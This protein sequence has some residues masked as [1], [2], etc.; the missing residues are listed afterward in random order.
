MSVSI[1]KRRKSK[2]VK[3]PEDVLRKRDPL[4]EAHAVGERELRAL[5]EPV[6]SVF[7]GA[8]R[9]EIEEIERND[10]EGMLAWGVRSGY[11]WWVRTH[12]GETPT[13]AHLAIWHAIAIAERMT[14]DCTD[15]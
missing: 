6:F 4:S 14:R 10:R 13:L 11:F 12:P 1:L 7:T 8:Q 5:W 15:D 9:D 3:I 2:Q